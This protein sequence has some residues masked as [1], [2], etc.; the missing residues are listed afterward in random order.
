MPLFEVSD[1]ATVRVL[2]AAGLGLSVAPPSWFEAP[3][4]P[5]AE[6]APAPAPLHAA[7]LLAPAG[8]TSPA[9]ALLLEALRSEDGVEL[10]GEPPARPCG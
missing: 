8:D 1:A 6:I 2:A 5:V 3:G 10:G 4:P 9:G 7:T